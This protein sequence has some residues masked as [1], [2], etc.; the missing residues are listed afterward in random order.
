MRVSC[1][2]KSICTKSM[3]LA[4]D[5][6]I[7]YRFP[8]SKS[9]Q[10]RSAFII[11]SGRGAVTVFYE[12]WAMRGRGE[13][14]TYGVQ[15]AGSSGCWTEMRM[16]DLTLN[17]TVSPDSTMDPTGMVTVTIVVLRQRGHLHVAETETGS[18]S[19]RIMDG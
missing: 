13:A 9:A 7:G 6:T 18:T 4:L 19:R 17:R 2:P 10:M 5:E 16:V 8:E 15:H 14:P 12:G 3:D 1:S 11:R